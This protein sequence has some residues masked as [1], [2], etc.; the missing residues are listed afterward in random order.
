MMVML[1]MQERLRL[2]LNVM[3]VIVAIKIGP[4]L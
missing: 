4:I 3:M 2:I 1:I